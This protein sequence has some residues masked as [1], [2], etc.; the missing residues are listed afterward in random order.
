[1]IRRPSER[2]VLAS[3]LVLS[4]A[5]L[6]VALRGPAPQAAVAGAPVSN[7]LGPADALLLSTEA[8]K[9]ALRVA[10]KDGRIAWGDR[11]TNR[12][13]SV[14]A[15]D[16]DKAMKRIL[17]GKSYEER[18]KEEQEKASGEEADFN[19]RLEELRAKYPLAE[20]AAP[21]PEAQQ[22]FG[23]LQQQYTQWLEGV[24]RRS[25]KMSSEQFEQAYRELVA[26][27][28]AVA[29]K[30]SIDIVFRF[31]PTASPFGTDRMSDT[32]GQ[33]QARTF[34]KYPEA[35]DITED[36]LKALNLAE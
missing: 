13:W 20:G 32:V 31:Y 17:A 1:M 33:I 10:A 14:A 23:V 27:V 24:R 12:V 26:A 34:L 9:D 2:L 18:R 19:K 22:E 36:V 7:D 28:E 21:P 30:E 15:V 5:A 6:V 29:E 35:I 25:E 3:S 11:S 16:I 4:A 8:G